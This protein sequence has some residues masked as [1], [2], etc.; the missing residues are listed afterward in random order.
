MSTF[1]LVL[2]TADAVF[3]TSVSCVYPKLTIHVSQ[4]LSECQTRK[5]I[6]DILPI[7]TREYFE[8]IDGYSRIWS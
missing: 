6:N 7:G 3:M 8:S 2:H 1:I 4:I 5:K